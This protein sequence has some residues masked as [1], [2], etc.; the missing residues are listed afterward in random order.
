M[1]RQCNP[2]I[3]KCLQGTNLVNFSK[4]TL[5]DVSSYF[6]WSSGRDCLMI[7][8]E[9]VL[10]S[11]Q[12]LSSII[13][14]ISWSTNNPWSYGMYVGFGIIFPLTGIFLNEIWHPLIAKFPDYL[15]AFSDSLKIKKVSL[16]M[17]YV[18]FFSDSNLFS[19]RCIFY[20][21]ICGTSFR[22]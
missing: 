6:S 4:C 13:R 9:R 11:A 18:G 10:F 21:D 3:L 22:R 17:A 16:P 5:Q 12:L 14:E 8:S 19:G 15:S 2:S 7:P 20:R 1:F